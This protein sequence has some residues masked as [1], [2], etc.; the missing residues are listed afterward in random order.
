MAKNA[1]K[2]QVFNGELPAR[3]ITEQVDLFV[4]GN[5]WIE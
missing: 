1:D 3:V 5:V 2:V 4:Y